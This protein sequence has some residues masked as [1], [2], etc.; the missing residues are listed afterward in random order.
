MSKSQ[1]SLSLED[2]HGSTYLAL[3]DGD[4]LRTAT[5]G[6][7]IVVD[8]GVGD[9]VIGIEFLFHAYS[10]AQIEIFARHGFSENDMAV[11]SQLFTSKYSKF[12]SKAAGVWSIPKSPFQ[13]SAQRSFA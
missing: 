4:V 9:E 2:Q 5:I 11:I 1:I 3:R 13:F 7:H 6:D 8:Y 12:E 10:T